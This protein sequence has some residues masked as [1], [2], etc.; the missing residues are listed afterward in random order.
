MKKLTF[1]QA[2]ATE[3]VYQAMQSGQLPQGRIVAVDGQPLG[4]PIDGVVRE[5]KREASR[6]LE[7]QNGS[8]AEH[9]AASRDTAKG[10][11]ADFVAA[12]RTTADRLGITALAERGMDALA[13]QL[14]ESRVIEHVVV[15]VQG[16]SRTTSYPI[17]VVDPYASLTNLNVVQGV[18]AAGATPFLG[19]AIL[20]GGAAV[21]LNRARQAETPAQKTVN[22]ANAIK[23]GIVGLVRLIPFTEP[24]PLAVVAAD[25]ATRQALRKRASYAELENPPQVTAA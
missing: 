20:F 4:G 17:R 16:D 6:F 13:K 14:P 10:R 8:D 19:A 5:A 25:V 11:F 18:I 24:I 3:L 7:Q 12:A 21:C 23:L 15:D 9:A 1:A 2:A 22:Y